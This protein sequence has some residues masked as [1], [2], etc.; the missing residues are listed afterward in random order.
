MK[1]SSRFSVAV[2]IGALL[3]TERTAV[4]TSEWM[5]ASVNT[6]PV[7]I[8]RISAQLKKA[9]IIEGRSGTGGAK[10]ANDPDEL[11]LLDFYQA[12]QVVADNELFHIHSEPNPNCYVGANIQGVLE[13]MLG[14]AQRAME[15][16]LAS[17]TLADV[18]ASFPEKIH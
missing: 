18:L 3:A 15:E 9:G 7:V 11:T 16:V 2:H 12:V 14:K 1:I 17:M 5:A 10:L 6:N 13:V 8:R 4:L